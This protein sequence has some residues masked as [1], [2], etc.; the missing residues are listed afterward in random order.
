MRK[1]KCVLV[2]ALC[3][4]M[5]LVL[6]GC[7]TSMTYRKAYNLYTTGDYQEAVEIFERLGDYGESKLMISSC[8]YEL[9]REAMLEQQWQIAIDY[10]SKSDYEGAAEKIKECQGKLGQ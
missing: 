2:L 8:Y 5:L 6:T 7:T 9:G 3:L 1:S 4:A 10:F